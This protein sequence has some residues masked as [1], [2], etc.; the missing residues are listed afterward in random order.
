MNKFAK[1]DRD[2]GTERRS[3]GE[4]AVSKEHGFHAYAFNSNPTKP[5]LTEH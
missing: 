2:G 1:S 4:N 3:K 5:S